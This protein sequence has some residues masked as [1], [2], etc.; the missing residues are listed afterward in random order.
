MA[1]RLPGAPSTRLHRMG[2]IV[3][4]SGRHSHPARPRRKT[5]HIARHQRSPRRLRRSLRQRARHS[6]LGTQIVYGCP[7]CT[8]GGESG[9]SFRPEKRALDWGGVTLTPPRCS[10][11]GTTSLASMGGY[12]FRLPRQL[13]SKKQYEE[14]RPARSTPGAGVARSAV[15]TLGDKLTAFQPTALGLLVCRTQPPVT[16]QQL[17]RLCLYLRH[18]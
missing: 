18:A 9:K 7:Q 12:L 10:I 13:P 6:R 16:H 8:K 17:Q 5:L 2:R 4:N 1:V 14:H 15:Q 3:S 11:V